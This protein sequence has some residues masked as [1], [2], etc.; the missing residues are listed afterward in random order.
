MFGV[1]FLQAGESWFQFNCGVCS[2]WVELDRCLV[3]ASWLRE[4]GSG[5]WNLISF[6]W[7]PVQCPAVSFGVSMGLVLLWESYPLMFEAVFLF[8]WRISVE[9]C[10]FLDGVWPQWRYGDLG[11]LTSINVPWGQEFYDGPKFWSWAFCLWVS[12]LTSYSSIKTSV[13]TQHRR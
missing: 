13:S 11:G 2:L 1:S 7:K 6:L 5:A 10:S 9:S 3:K 12:V 4:P 8:Y